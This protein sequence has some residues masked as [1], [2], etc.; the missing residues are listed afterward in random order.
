MDVMRELSVLLDFTNQNRCSQDG[1]GAAKTREQSR[2]SKHRGAPLPGLTR[3][4]AVEPKQQ[5]LAKSWHGGT[6][7]QW[8]RPTGAGCVVN[9]PVTKAARAHHGIKAASLGSGFGE[10]GRTR[11][12]PLH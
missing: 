6:W 1:H 4:Q 12:E 8:R 5:V 11:A 3:A 2:E 7:E 10:T 9:E